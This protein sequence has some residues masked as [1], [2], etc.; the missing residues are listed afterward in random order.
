[1]LSVD[2]SALNSAL[3]TDLRDRAK[4]EVGELVLSDLI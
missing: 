3:N 4:E 2:H 1:M